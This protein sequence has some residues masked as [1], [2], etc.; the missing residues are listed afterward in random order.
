MWFLRCSKQK[1][2]NEKRKYKNVKEKEK[3]NTRKVEQLKTKNGTKNVS[4]N[5]IP[6][7]YS[8]QFLRGRFNTWA[9]L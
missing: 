4:F 2:K 1:Q 5:S 9:L 8:R 7:I 3:K 6:N